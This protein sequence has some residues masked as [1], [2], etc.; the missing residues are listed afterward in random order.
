MI[1]LTPEEGVFTNLTSPF[2]PD[3]YPSVLCLWLITTTTADNETS[4]ILRFVDFDLETRY[5]YLHLGYG[6]P[7]VKDNQVLTLSG[8]MA[9]RTFRVGGGDVMWVRFISEVGLWATRGF[10]ALLE[11][12]STERE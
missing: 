5:D 8:S 1:T 7:E 2:Y 9:P 11:A 10:Y 3:P 6:D 12:Q 4:M